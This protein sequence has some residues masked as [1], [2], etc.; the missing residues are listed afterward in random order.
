MPEQELEKLLGGFAADTLTQEER[1]R[2][3]AA[4]LQ[5]QALFNALS[6]E[7]A[8]KELLSDPAVRRRLIQALKQPATSEARSERSWWDWFRR[9]AGLAVAGGLAA[10]IFAVAFGTSIYQES[11][12][13]AAQSVATE[14][15]Q[16]AAP[17]IQ[18]PQPPP[19]RQP[20]EPEPRLTAKQLADSATA[21]AQT[22]PLTNKPARREQPTPALPE[23]QPKAKTT[24]DNAQPP[25]ER[26]ASREQPRAP[27]ADKT[28]EQATASADKKSFAGS[29][30][31]AASAPAAVPSLRQTQA[32]SS[33]AGLITPKL[34]ARALFYGEDP[35]RTEG[36][37]QENERAMQQPAE[38]APQTNRMERRMDQFASAGKA[39]GSAGQLKPLGLRYSF[40]TRGPDGQSQEVTASTAAGSTEPVRITVETTQDA[41]LQ[42]LQNLGSAGTRLWWPSQ[43]TGK[44]SLKV[45]AGKR[46]EIPM[47]PPAEGGLLSLTVRLSLKPFAPLTMQEVGMLDRF[48]ANLL[49]ESISPSRPAGLDEEA[50]YVMNNSSSP[51]AQLA[52]EIPLAR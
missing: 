26:D 40:V 30:A 34:S 5:D 49:V 31:P 38:P 37:A 8:L 41:Y 2:L 32:D 15:A 25:R 45:L 20:A 23:K 21:P 48:S 12:D 29:P 4:A 9:P 50:T 11:L 6:D 1:F 33:A 51:T 28:A 24:G 3:Y 39:A 43:E 13:R 17:S 36:M 19:P 22:E 7:Q 18:V 52:V 35:S 10:T 14:A 27:A 44:I 16:Q 47:P 46:T 42:I